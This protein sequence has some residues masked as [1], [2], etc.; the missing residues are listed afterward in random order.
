MHANGNF[1]GRE[2]EMIQRMMLSLFL[3]MAGGCGATIYPQ[4]TPLHPTAVYL[5]D[6]GVH[7]SLLLPTDDGRYVEYAFGDWN[8]A[9]LNHCLPHEALAALLVSFQST[10]G[11]RYIEPQPG[12]TEP[13]PVHPSPHSIQRV[14]AP[15]D[16]V[17]RVVRELD[18]R[19]RH[20]RGECRHNPDNNMDYVRDKEHYWVANNCNHLTVRCLEEMG[21][22]VRG[23]VMLP[24]FTVAPVQKGLLPPTEMARTASVPGTMPSAA[25][26]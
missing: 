8:F 19:Y 9:A 13:H 15:Q 6:Y 21:C 7:S 25:L 11:R 12:Q 18:E 16:Q 24:G 22:R 4:S 1:P 3:S 14:Y 23:L 10:L 17:Q 2:Y 26:P 5:A 20:D